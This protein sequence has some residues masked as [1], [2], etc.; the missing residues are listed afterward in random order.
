ML[1]G[2]VWM[3][4]LNPTTGRQQSGRRPAVIVSADRVN[5]GPSGLV[6]VLPITGTDRKLP[7][8]VP[9]SPPDGGLVK[10]SVVMV[11]QVRTVSVH[12]LERRTGCL[13]PAVVAVI[14]ARLKLLV[15]I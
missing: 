15:G 3:V 11:D 1:R 7:M 2:E 10:P 9:V 12:R 14:D 4:D 13:S 5:S 8:H 6:V